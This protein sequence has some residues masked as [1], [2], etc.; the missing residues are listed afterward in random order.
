MSLRVATES[1]SSRG[2]CSLYYLLRTSLDSQHKSC[3]CLQHSN[4][5]A[6]SRRSHCASALRNHLPPHVPPPKPI[7]IPSAP[8]VSSWNRSRHRRRIVEAMMI[9][10]AAVDFSPR[11]CGWTRVI[12]GR[13]RTPAAVLM[14]QI[15]AMLQGG[16]TAADVL[17]HASCGR[18]RRGSGCAA[19]GVKDD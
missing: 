6:W 17:A 10:G 18:C 19:G 3:Q 4:P 2:A 9:R 14:M 1:C 5:Q 12:R 7:V 11:I 13:D 8:R 15:G 16:V